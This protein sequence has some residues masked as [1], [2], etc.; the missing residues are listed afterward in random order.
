V[1]IDFPNFNLPSLDFSAFLGP[2][3]QII[4]I[5]V[6]LSGDNAVVIG[7]A[8]SALPKSQR[9]LGIFFGTGAAIMLRV[10]LITIV[11]E[12]LEVPALRLIGSL[13]L[14]WI[15]IQLAVEQHDQ[16]DVPSGGS[17]FAAIR[18]IVV[19]DAVMSL[20]NVMAIAAAAKGSL[21]L[22][23]FGLILSVPLIIF[24]S[25]LLLTLF[26]RF[27]ILV[28][29]GA[30]VLGYVAGELFASEPLLRP[31]AEE[32]VRSLALPSMSYWEI[33][34]GLAGALLV[35][36]VALGLRRIASEQG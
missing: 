8:C 22:V 21:L 28:L 35:L 25:T 11:V 18:I 6:V 1:T 3:L 17:L 10:L 7:L 5:D 23:A 36:G 32:L 20:D 27:P 16:K 30:A 12:L 15:A 24:G 31:A 29:A 19:A 13:M 2:V 14:F 26:N 34:C 33:V 9:R 4:W